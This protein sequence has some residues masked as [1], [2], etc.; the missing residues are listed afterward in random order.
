TAPPPPRAAAAEEKPVA[1]TA[2]E[3][4]DLKEALHGPGAPLTPDEAAQRAVKTAPSMARAEA[5]ANQA[6][7][8]A[9]QANVALYPRLDLTARYSRLSPVS[10]TT[11]AEIFGDIG[12]AAGNPNP[13]TAG[14]ENQ[15]NVGQFQASL[16]WPVTAFFFSIIPRYKAFQKQAD[17][18]RLTSRVT[19]QS[20]GLQARETY[21]NYART[22]AQ[23]LVARS[24]EAQT[25]AHRKDVEALVNAGSMAKVEYMRAEA[26]VA[27]AKVNTVRAQVAVATARSALFTITHIEGDQD[28]TINED[29]T[30]ELPPLA[31]TSDS[32]LAKALANRSE[33]KQL[34][35]QL[36]A[37]EHTVDAQQG[38]Q[39]PQIVLG[40]SAEYSIPNQRYFGENDKWNASWVL[41]AAATW[42]P[43]DWAGYGKGADQARAQ[44]AQTVADL[45]Q[46]EDNLRIEVSESYEAYNAARAA[47]GAARVGIA[48]A[49]ESYRV[50][51]EQFRAGSAVATEVIDS[52]TDLTNA[53]LD[54]VNAVIALRIAKAR[55]DRAVE[56][57]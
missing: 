21:F 39:L 23:L 24:A 14:L 56:A 47:L 26:Q 57:S 8:A 1:T 2:A 22:R 29:F 30:V 10:G 52:E 41:F 42:S 46:L 20:V 13:N 17:A 38:Q 12:M 55:L 28:L 44:M 40:G 27:A 32:L 43:N 36:E 15:Y 5:A 45:E 35:I 34:R 50:R 33:L 25:E 49:E 37:I 18:Q 19:A 7:Y 53:R 31:D 16:Q 54:L 11:L 6:R 51:R 4:F 3:G 48:A 9:E